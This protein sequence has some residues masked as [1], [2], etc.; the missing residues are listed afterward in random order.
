MWKYIILAIMWGGIIFGWLIPMIRKRIVYE[1]YEACGLG[2]FF[3]ILILN[4]FP[5]W[6]ILRLRRIIFV[7]FR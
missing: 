7:L 5:R 1:I 4:R 3:T 6:I 2:G